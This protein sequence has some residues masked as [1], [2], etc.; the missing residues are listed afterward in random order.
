MVRHC[1]VL[2]LVLEAAIFVSLT[3]DRVCTCSHLTCY[4]K[5]NG[6]NHGWLGRA[7]GTNLLTMMCVLIVSPSVIHSAEFAG[8]VNHFCCFIFSFF[9]IYFFYSLKIS[10][11]FGCC[12]VA[13]A[14]ICVTVLIIII[15]SAI[16]PILGQFHDIASIIDFVWWGACFCLCLASCCFGS[17][18]LYFSLPVRLC[19]TSSKHQNSL[20]HS[21]GK[22]LLI[23]QSI[24]LRIIYEDTHTD[25]IVTAF[26]HLLFKALVKSYA[27]PWYIIHKPTTC[28]W[29]QRFNS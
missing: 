9:C 14:F 22:W 15:T 16:H 2:Q 5:H 27:L 11:G 3:H 4:H 29:Y 26:N 24:V 6:T 17:F 10:C 18:F 19:V 12:L 21:F 20:W 25:L 23:P 13:L 8:F 7:R 1:D 28:P